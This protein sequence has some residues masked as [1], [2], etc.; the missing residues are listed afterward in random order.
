MRDGHYIT[1]GKFAD[2][3]MDEIIANMVGREI[4]EQFPRDEAHQGKKVLEVKNLRAGRAVKGISFDAYEGEVLGFSGLVGA[5]RT[6]TMRAI[7]GA[8]AKDSGEVIL[9]GKPLNINS[10]ADAIRQGIVL[11]PEDRKKD[12][13]C[14]KLSIRENIALPNLDLICTKMGMVLRATTAGCCSKVAGAGFPCGDL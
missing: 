13:L 9:D 12:G 10:P 5:G 4:T 6:E 3:T 1:E 14:T 7:F 8:D 2:F 11:A